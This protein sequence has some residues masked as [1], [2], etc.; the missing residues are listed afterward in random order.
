MK[1]IA[2]LLILLLIPVAAAEYSVEKTDV[3]CAEGMVLC[4]DGSCR[5]SK[6]LCPTYEKESVAYE[7]EAVTYEKEAIA[8]DKE[9]SCDPF[10]TCESGVCVEDM[11][12]CSERANVPCREGEIL[13]MDGT[14]QPM[15]GS[16][17][18]CKG[19]ENE[20]G[21]PAVISDPIACPQ[22][23]I[24]CPDGSCVES[25]EQC[26][27]EVATKGELIDAQASTQGLSKI[28]G[29]SY[30]GDEDGY[31]DSQDTLRTKKGYD[32]YQQS[33]GDLAA[34]TDSGDCD[35][36][37]CERKPGVVDSGDCN[38]EDCSV[39]PGESLHKDGVIHRDVATRAMREPSSVTEDEKKQLRAVLDNKQT[40]TKEE[41]GLSVA[42]AVS[43][44]PRVKEVLFNNQTSE[45]K[46]VHEEEV[47]LFGFIRTTANAETIIDADG[48]MQTK[49]PWWARLGSVRSQF[50]PE[51]LEISVE[52]IER[53][54]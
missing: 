47:R 27:V 15:F 6:T 19:H 24:L 44:N 17:T 4:L 13:C 8:N 39:K 14:C 7:K 37:D 53:A 33:Q 18:P 23:S 21:E 2:L 9:L 49:R 50:N 29:K 54:K 31:G 22:N 36:T 11:T 42:L 26:P 1:H 28:D 51:N 12:L 40:L 3:R 45:T 30:D 5:E 41:F 20:E 25:K 16:I 43:D 34:V 48:N 46:I 32:H 52:K 35:D 10:Y 38:D